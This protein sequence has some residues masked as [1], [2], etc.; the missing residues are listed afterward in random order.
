MKYL[1]SLSLVLSGFITASA[2]QIDNALLL[3]YYQ[4]QRYA[5]AADYLKKNFPEPITDPKILSRIAYTLQ[6]N[7]NLPEAEHYYQRVY[8]I[9][10]TSTN[11][12]LSMANINMQRGNYP[13]AESYYKKILLTDT[14]SF[15]VYSDLGRMASFKNDTINAVNYLQKANRINPFDAFAASDLANF[16][17][18]KKK[19]DIALKVL[20]KAAENDPDDVYLLTSMIKFTIKQSKWPEAIAICEKMIKLGVG[21]GDVLYNMGYAYY[22]LRNYTCAAETF[23]NLAFKD[24][25]EASDYYMSLSYKY[26]KNNSWAI[27]YMNKTIDEGISK[28]VSTYYREI[29]DNYETLKKYKKAND[30]YMKSLEYKTAPMTY[31]LLANMYDTEANNKKLA[32]Q[33]YKKF[34]ANNPDPKESQKYIDYAKLR[35]PTLENTR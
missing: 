24:Q 32:I 5:E 34:L 27:Y 2:Q 18:F 1:L 6:M 7:H 10:T 13:K 3:D 11:A 23:A 29:A 20:N 21:D 28:N 26:L 9:D 8:E 15:N 12:L 17:I 14:T 22:N 30:A 16:Y 31:Y 19:Y 25:T 35:I 33:Y 4:N